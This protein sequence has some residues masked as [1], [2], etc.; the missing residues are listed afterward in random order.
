MTI[1]VREYTPETVG[2]MLA[3]AKARRARLYAPRVVVAPPAPAPIAKPQPVQT[4]RPEPEEAAPIPPVGRLFNLFSRWSDEDVRQLR[5]MIAS[6]HSK[7]DIAQVLGRTTRTVQVKANKLGLST[8][9]GILH[10]AIPPGQYESSTKADERI[11]EKLI[12]QVCEEF[13]VSR[14]ELLGQSRSEKI[15]PVRHEACWRIAKAT[16]LSLPHL[17]SIFN[18]DH[19]SIL[20]AIRK[21]NEVHGE[22]VRRMGGVSAYKRAAQIRYRAKHRAKRGL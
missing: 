19:T 13:E 5:E 20:H 8:R 9:A 16:S 15:V 2:Q 1:A 7:I 18:R 17:G 3:D 6:G 22:N 12:L 4:A 14:A 21:R 11:A 10:G